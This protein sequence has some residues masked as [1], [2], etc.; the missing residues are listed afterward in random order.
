MRFTSH[1]SAS[2][3]P[4]FVELLLVSLLLGP[5]AISVS[6]SPLN[7][8]VLVGLAAKRLQWVFTP[9]QVCVIEFR[10][11]VQWFAHTGSDY[12]NRFSWNTMIL[13]TET[14]TDLHAVPIFAVSIFVS[15]TIPQD[16]R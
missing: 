4:A 2:S 14:D 6:I 9:K 12:Q 10:S 16:L 11:S 5:N 3:L 7:N 13:C 1:R 8:Y 15:E